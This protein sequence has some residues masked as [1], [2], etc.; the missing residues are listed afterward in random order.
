RLDHEGLALWARSVEELPPQKDRLRIVAALYPDHV[1]LAL[2]RG[3]D[4]LNAHGFRLASAAELTQ[5]PDR[6]R[7]ILAAEAQPGTELDWIFCGPE[8]Q[9]AGRLDA[10]QTRLRTAWPGTFRTVDEPRLFL[11]RALAGRA[12]RPTPWSCNLR[13][14]ALAHPKARL[15][16]ARRLRHKALLLLLT[17]LLL[18]GLNV[19]WTVAVRRG[20]A[21]TTAAVTALARELAPQAS[22]P[23]GQELHAVQK[24]LDQEKA[25]L[26]PFLRAV[27]P[28]LLPGL[29]A[30]LDTARGNGASLETL[31]LESQ[32]LALTGSASGAEACGK[33]EQ[34][35]KTRGYSTKVE[36]RKAAGNRIAFSM[37][38]ERPE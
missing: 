27:S 21:A 19:G 34:L 28:S 38:G 14:G 32:T 9:D 24:T 26:Q 36:Q 15:R 4:F 17:G 31:T 25:P 3:A 20:L 22:I 6:L 1:A 10:L 11:A 12:L 8:A 33:L 23:Y 16:S 18:C 30:L 37:R 5:L 29:S 2:G 35:L 13:T 7:R